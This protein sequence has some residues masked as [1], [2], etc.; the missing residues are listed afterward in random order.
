[1]KTAT[2]KPKRTRNRLGSRELVRRGWGVAIYRDD[3]T[4]F[5]ACSGAGVLPFVHVHRK[6]A[7]RHKRS[8]ID[9]FKCRVVPV[10]FTNP[11]MLPPN[12]KV[13]NSGA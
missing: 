1:M 3:G 10:S 2:T 9:Y 5:L 7:V 8:L 13:T 6:E 11:V 4:C 12:N